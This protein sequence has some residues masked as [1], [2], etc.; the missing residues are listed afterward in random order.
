MTTKEFTFR[1]SGVCPVSVS[2]TLDYDETS[3]RAKD[4]ARIRDVSFTGGCSGNL[5]FLSKV[6]EEY[7]HARWIA[8]VARGIH[9]GARGTSCA[10]EF[11]KAVESA[12][13]EI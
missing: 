5:R 7:G 4:T 13:E 9:C 10:N 11:S 6:A 12:I 1:L 8:D 3:E 2:F